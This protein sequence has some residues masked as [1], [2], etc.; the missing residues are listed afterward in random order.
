L[1]TCSAFVPSYDPPSQP[2]HVVYLPGG[3]PPAR[4]RHFVDFIV[5]RFARPAMP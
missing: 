3:T 1:A 5:E 2:M 4:V